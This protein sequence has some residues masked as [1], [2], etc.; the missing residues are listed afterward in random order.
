MRLFERIK[1]YAVFL[2]FIS[3][4]N[5]DKGTVVVLRDVDRT[6]LLFM[7]ALISLEFGIFGEI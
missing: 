6:L 1:K 5:L 2:A 3:A 4:L 7:S